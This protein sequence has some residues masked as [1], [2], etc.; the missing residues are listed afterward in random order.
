MKIDKLW[1]KSNIFIWF[2][3]PFSIIF[4]LITVIRKT[5]Y[6]INLLKSYRSKKPIIIVGNISVGGTGKT[7]LTIWLV[8]NLQKLGFKVGVVSRG[9]GSEAPFYP[10]VIE[11]NSPVNYCGDEPYLIYS[12]CKCPVVIAPKRIEAVK[13]LEK[14]NVD[15]IISD[16]GLQHYAMERDFE[17]VVVDGERRFGN[18]FVMPMGP[19]RE[20]ISRTKTVDAIVCNGGDKL[21]NEYKMILKLNNVV[22]I[23]DSSLEYDEDDKKV[24]AIAGIGNPERF[25]RSIESLG[26]EI[27]Q[28]YACSDHAKYDQIGILSSVKDVKVPIIMTEKD[29]VKCKSFACNNWYYL[30]IDAQVDQKLLEKIIKKLNL[31]INQ[32]GIENI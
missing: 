1:Y 2:L 6:N 12:R 5:L 10:Y 32:D 31:K 20:P 4:W 9:Y 18:G 26:Y 8:Q 13:I 28:K 22:K 21:K 16:D 30:P 11:S 3:F 27:Q 19:L 24:N 15:I 17:I 23:S 14:K 25:F 29:A 7:P